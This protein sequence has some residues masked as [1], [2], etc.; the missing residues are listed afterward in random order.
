MFIYLL[1]LGWESRSR[2]PWRSTTPV[3]YPRVWSAGGCGVERTQCCTARY[4]SAPR[5]REGS[6]GRAAPSLANPCQRQTPSSGPLASWY[7]RLS[8]MMQWWSLLA[9]YLNLSMRAMMYRSY[10]QTHHCSYRFQNWCWP[11]IVGQFGIKSFIFSSSTL[12]GS[13]SYVYCKD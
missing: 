4:L 7:P 5:S 10:W 1:V 11:P 2:S 8:A 6:L 13:L 9:K 3:V 12:E